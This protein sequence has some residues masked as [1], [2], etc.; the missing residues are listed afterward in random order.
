MPKASLI[1][2]VRA[3][4]EGIY[5]YFEGP[6]VLVKDVYTLEYPVYPQNIP[7]GGGYRQSL[8]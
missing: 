2:H 7:T 8:R 4:Y 3:L 5:R 1:S 6:P